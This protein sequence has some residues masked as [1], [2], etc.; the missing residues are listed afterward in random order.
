MS[1]R[2]NGQSVG[3]AVIGT[4]TITVGDCIRGTVQSITDFGAFIRVANKETDGVS[5]DGLLH[6]SQISKTERV[7]NVRDYL[8]ESQVVEVYVKGIVELEGDNIRISL[9]LFNPEDAGHESA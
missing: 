1:F 8:Q 4:K 9:S 5:K 2:N 6:I 3:S 7:E